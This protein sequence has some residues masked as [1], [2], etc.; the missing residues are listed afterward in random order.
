[1]ILKYFYF[2]IVFSTFL[3]SFNIK[4]VDLTQ[5]GIKKANEPKPLYKEMAD[6]KKIYYD[7]GTVIKDGSQSKV[8]NS[9]S[10]TI[11]STQ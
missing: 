6:G 8:K 9:S 3:Y 5:E 11:K 7:V 4:P 1:M 2:I 10:T